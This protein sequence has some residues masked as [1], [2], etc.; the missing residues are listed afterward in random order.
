M[1]IETGELTY[2]ETSSTVRVGTHHKW[3]HN[4][5]ANFSQ[6]RH[7]LNLDISARQKVCSVVYAYS[8]M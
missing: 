3:M 1:N 2:I 4:A 7:G 6:E 5:T 8:N